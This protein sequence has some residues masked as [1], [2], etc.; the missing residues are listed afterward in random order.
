MCHT[1]G[2]H[3]RYF[4]AKRVGNEFKNFFVAHLTGFFSPE[5]FALDWGIGTDDSVIIKNI[6]YNGKVGRT[7]M[8]ANANGEPSANNQISI[9]V[10]LIQ[11]G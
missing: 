11:G 5:P 9:P 6:S 4:L 7:Y 8:I 10:K 1:T 3:Q 2:Y